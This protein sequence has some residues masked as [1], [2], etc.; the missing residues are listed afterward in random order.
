[1]IAKYRNR[2]LIYLTL[3]SALTVAIAFLVHKN[4]HTR[5]SERSSGLIAFGVIGYIVAWI[6]WVLVGFSLARA[7]GYSQDFTGTLFMVVY[8][9]GLCFPVVVVA[10]PLYILFG[11]EDKA[12]NR[13]RR[14]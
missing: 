3:A 1:M 11:M 10:F 9:I 12:K 8:F 13:S 14:H 4:M 7:K 2:T 6:S 5:V